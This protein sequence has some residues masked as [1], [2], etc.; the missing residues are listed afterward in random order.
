MK[1]S[2]IPKFVDWSYGSEEHPDISRS[3]HWLE[4][5]GE[6]G[7]YDGKKS[8]MLATEEICRAEAARLDLNAVVIRT[9][10]HNKR[11]QHNID[12]TKKTYECQY[13]GLTKNDVKDADWDFTV[14]MGYHHEDLI[15]QGH[16]YVASDHTARGGLRLSAE[17]KHKNQYNPDGT[18]LTYED[19]RTRKPKND[20][21]DA[22]WHFT[23]YMG[24]DEN[25]HIIQ[26][27]RPHL[28][29]DV[30]NLIVHGH[31]YIVW[32]HT[33]M[34]GMRIVRDATE[35]KHPHGES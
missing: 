23:A 3:V 24:Y 17:R 19:T 32:D 9:G 4:T 15:V 27:S 35:R 7:N 1:P 13:S 10:L 31:I 6:N 20:V 8:L 21:T 2:E 26:E 12:G 14:Y 5:W 29:H 30:D 18:I 22:D 11:N 34:F 25:N 33:A 28:W 16:I